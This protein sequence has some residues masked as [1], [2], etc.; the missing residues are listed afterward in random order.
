MDPGSAW[1]PL[2]R[3]Q[4]STVARSS[5][6]NLI[7]CVRKRTFESSLVIRP[8]SLSKL[9]VL[10]GKMCYSFSIMSIVRQIPLLLSHL[11]VQGAPAGGHVLSLDGDLLVNPGDLRSFIEDAT[12]RIGVT[13]PVSSE[14]VYAIFDQHSRVIAFSRESSLSPSSEWSGLFR[15]D[16]KS[17]QQSIDNGEHRGHVYEML[18]RHLPLASKYIDAAEIDTPEDYRRAE[19]WLIA[20]A[21]AW[22]NDSAS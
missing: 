3:L 13:D 12:L 18:T 9:Y 7:Y 4:K 22:K 8:R 10:S 6:G 19:S 21:P 11:A 15:L 2:K 20:R 14:P 1:A 5:H 16:I 17:L